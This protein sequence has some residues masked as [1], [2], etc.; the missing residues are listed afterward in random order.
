MS[1]LVF[2]STVAPFA[3]G[4]PITITIT[5][6]D[7]PTIGNVISVNF[8]GPTNFTLTPTVLT[9]PPVGQT[10]WDISTAL[11]PANSFTFGAPF[12]GPTFYF[13]EP[14]PATENVLMIAKT[15]DITVVSDF[16]VTGVPSIP[17]GTKTQIGFDT[18][19]NVVSVVFIDNLTEPGDV[20]TP[21]PPTLL[22]IPVLGIFGVAWR[23]SSSGRR[24]V[25]ALVFVSLF[26]RQ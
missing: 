15:T 22:L 26:D 19:G 8:G 24:F 14:D 13:A 9:L 6:L 20:M 25:S 16:P 5:E 18:L 12:L 7:S 2:Q 10:G 21:E 1:F 11:D 17:N 4:A 3:R 23:R